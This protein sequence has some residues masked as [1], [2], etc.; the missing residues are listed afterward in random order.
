MQFKAAY[1]RIL[2][3]NEVVGSIFGNSSILDNTRN[4]SVTEKTKDSVLTLESTWLPQQDVHID[5]D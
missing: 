4:L 2:V 3:H 1:K 5:H